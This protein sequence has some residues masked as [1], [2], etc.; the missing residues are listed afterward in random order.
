MNGEL[1]S[2]N[3]VAKTQA[4]QA[5]IS[6]IAGHYSLIN[7]DATL[8]DFRA[9]VL[10]GEVTA[11]GTIKNIAGDS[12][13]KFNATLHGISLSDAKRTI[14]AAASTG[15]ATIA[16]TLD[17]TATASW[18]KSFDDLIAHTDATIRAGLANAHEFETSRSTNA[19]PDNRFEC[20]ANSWAY[21]D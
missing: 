19:P 6:N 11:Q 1:T 9:S 7:G 18:G 10:G 14:G 4:A 21:P 3:L 20:R 8:R 17:A 5:E 16:G 2:R 15:A 12:H 13:S